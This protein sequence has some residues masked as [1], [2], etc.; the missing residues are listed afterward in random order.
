[1]VDCFVFVE[2]ACT[3]II[4]EKSMFEGFG[5]GSSRFTAVY[6]NLYNHCI[7]NP[8]ETVEAY[9]PLCGW[10]WLFMNLLMFAS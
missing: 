3:T 1:M 5:P 6:I 7:L 8:I 4:C 10:F 2:E 9:L